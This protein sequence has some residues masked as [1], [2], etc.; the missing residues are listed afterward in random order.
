[1]SSAAPSGCPV[2]TDFAFVGAGEAMNAFRRYDALQDA[3]RI[4]RV[5]EPGGSYYVV[6]DR[7]LIVAGMQDP[8]TFSSH[9]LTPLQPNPVYTMIPIML[10]PPEHTKWRRLLSSYF[11]VRRIPLL[12]PRIRAVGSELIEGFRAEGACDYVTDFAF[13]FPTTIFLEIM[14]L[15]IEEL[16]TFMEW[17]RAI[18]HP[19]A[20]GSLD[21]ERQIA[22]VMAVF[23]RLREII[24]DRRSAPDSDADDIVS[25]AAG[26]EMDGEPVADD[27]I[28]SCCLLLFMAGLD[29]VANVLS[30][31]MSHLATHP[32]EQAFLAADTSRA[33]AA[34]EE[35]L[36]AFAIAQLA[37]KVTTE[38]VIAGVELH[39]GDMVLFPLA[40]ANRDT[41][42]VDHAREVDFGREPG[43]HY[44]FGAGPHRCLGSHLARRE[45]AVALELWHSAI[46]SYEL[47]SAAPL[48][49][50]WGHVHGLLTL[51]LR[52]R[53]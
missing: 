7:E 32:S 13:R 35:L 52:W 16:D 24:A 49:G 36:R 2:V 18:L 46:P 8:V 9:A 48:D 12:D 14:G 17:E 22:G 4:V 1:M 50:H 51:P 45:M 29:T 23:G 40:A 27:D 15:P 21:R 38:T 31:S 41:A 20:D 47:A 10:D 30:F 53:A 26:W 42:H 11:A 34:T 6:L 44:A 37:R 43:P 19:D 5:E 3:H 25:H 28:V 33:T 39:P